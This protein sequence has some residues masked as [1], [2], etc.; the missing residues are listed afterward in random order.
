MLPHELQ[1]D[2]DI[3]ERAADHDRDIQARNRVVLG[4]EVIQN[5]AGDDDR[6]IEYG[7]DRVLPS[8]SSVFSDR[9]A[10]EIR[11]KQGC[12]HMTGK[13]KLA[14]VEDVVL[15][16]P[17]GKGGEKRRQIYDRIDPC[18][19]PGRQGFLPIG[20]DIKDKDDQHRTHAITVDGHHGSKKGLRRSFTDPVLQNRL[21][22]QAEGQQQNDQDVP[23]VLMVDV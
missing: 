19:D 1:V 10:D 12:D 22:N 21:Q 20:D 17:K 5:D 9:Q 4:G 18:Q 11:K 16:D 14:S 3:V 2:P 23:F 13:P 7:D 6:R 15:C 8:N